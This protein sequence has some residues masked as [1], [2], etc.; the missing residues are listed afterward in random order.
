M[1]DLHCAYHKGPRHETDHCTALRHTIQDLI[2]QGL[3]CLGQ[4]NVT[5]NPLPAHT[6]H[7]VLLPADGIHFMDFTKLDDHIHMLSWAGSKLEPIVVDES[8]EVD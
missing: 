6:S 8:Y 7:A 4:P 1:M 5:T 2:D 3:V